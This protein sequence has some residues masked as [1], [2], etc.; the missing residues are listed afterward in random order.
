MLLDE[1]V[2]PLGPRRDAKA[3]RKAAPSVDAEALDAARRV[4]DEMGLRGQ[5]SAA[6]LAARFA[7]PDAAAVLDPDDE[8]REYGHVLVDEAQD[9]TPMQWRAI[10]RRCPSGSMTLVGDFGQVSR[11]GACSGWDEVLTHLPQRRPPPLVELT[12]NYRTPAEIMEVANRLLVVAAPTVT[13]TRA[14]RS[15]GRPPV[16]ERVT[17]ADLIAAAAAE[18]RR[19]TREDGTV[20]VV[21]PGRLLRP[22]ADELAD[23]GA[24]TASNEALD[25]PVAVLGAD[26][27]KGLEFDVVVVV[28]PAELAAEGGGERGPEVGLRR[29]FVSATRAT[30]H[31]AVV[32]AADLPPGLSPAAAAA[33]PASAGPAPP[34]PAPAPAAPAPATP[35]SVAPSSSAPSRS[36]PEPEPEPEPSAPSRLFP[37]R[38]GW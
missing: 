20:A 28:E 7:A 26:E 18:A 29:L 8:P 6:D 30:R 34:A 32:H 12:V 21:A 27:V 35:S 37:E 33:A 9:L 19:A 38:P 5:M 1:L 17:P 24:R 2:G 36:A 11:P 22:L 16:F 14:V 23:V 10:G 3:R 25:A 4:V 31:L 15:T 13:P